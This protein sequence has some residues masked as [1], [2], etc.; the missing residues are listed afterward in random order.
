[1]VNKSGIL[2]CFFA[3]AVLFLSNAAADDIDNY[4]ASLSEADAAAQMFLINI[5]GNSSYSAVE[6]IDGSPLVPGG[7]I[8]F[9]FN[10]APSA[11][12]IISYTSSAASYCKKNNKPVPYIAIDQ[13]GGLVNRLRDITSP[14][15]S[16]SRLAA[17]V[18][19][20]SAAEIYSAQARQLR[21]LGITMNLAPVA[22][23]S[24]ESNKD[25]LGTR[26]FGSVANACVYSFVAISAYEKNGVGSVLKHFPGNTNTDPHTG[27]PFIELSLKELKEN[28]IVPFAFA[29]ESSPSAVLM[30]HAV[31]KVADSKTPACLSE[32][33]TREVLQKQLG[34][35]G[36]II[37][38]D[39]F[40]KAL[41]DNGF[42]PEKAVLMA[43]RAGVDVIML[44]EKKFANVVS[45]LLS[46]AHADKSFSESLKKSQR[47]IIEFKLSKG[48]LKRQNGKIVSAQAV[49]SE[50]SVRDFYSAKKEGD[51]LYRQLF[52]NGD[53][54]E[55]K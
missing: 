4:L 45:I 39:I 40:M 25:F 12:Q 36:L 46:Y 32:Y 8:L 35:G 43:V 6:E 27:L 29:L 28:F 15:P 14:L 53:L 1:M 10:I 20:S 38:D 11:E 51:E 23:P 31:T 33:W 30:S 9:S 21:A 13:E 48:I 18:S 5:E 52:L 17:R 2:K 19:P 26:S 49:D 44:S 37:S 24:V 54:N 34:Y 16:E 42:P 3:V 55:K 47:K 41:A 7:C 22:E 50:Q